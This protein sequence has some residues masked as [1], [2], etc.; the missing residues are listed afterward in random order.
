MRGQSFDGAS[1]MTGSKNGVVQKVQQI[2]PRAVF[3]HCNG[4]LINL[5]T[6]DSVKSSKILSEALSNAYEI[7]KLIKKSP[8]R[9]ARFNKLKEEIGSTNTSIRAFS[10]TRWTV[11]ANSIKSIIDN[12]SLLIQ[13]FEQDLEESKMPL[14]MSTRIRGIVSIM[15]K[16]SCF[17]SFKLAY[18]I[19]RHTDSLATKIQKSDLNAAQGFEL[20]MMTVATLE[21]EKN[22]ANFEQ[23]YGI[24]TETAKS[25]KVDDPVLPRQRKIP[26][27]LDGTMKPIP[28]FSNVYDFY[29]FYYYEA[30]ETIISNI[31]ERFE[32]KG[33]KMVMTLE[34]LLLKSAM[35]RDYQEELA[36][37]TDFYGSDLNRNDLE[38]QLLTY[39]VKFMEFKT[40][41]VT[42]NDV[43]EFMRQPGYSDFFPEISTV[44]RLVL[45]LPASNAQSERVFSILKRIKT[46]IRNSMEQERLKNIMI[47]NIHSNEA[48]TLNLAEVA[49]DFV[50]ALPGRKSDFGDKKFV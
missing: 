3:I 46:P 2:E 24:V 13:T 37:V 5:A 45:V 48:K 17:F 4:H 36:E 14:E 33:Y 28:I 27:K 49:N 47:L 16:F 31:R 44:L 32:Q 21:A 7:E 41:N 10:R 42:L 18:F 20:A 9:E 35:W 29:K 1:N 22:E 30:L 43:I 11:K 26:I 38:I 8:K 19:L 6:S 40:G 25:Q 39:K 23:F 15:T 34:N 50:S 12:Y